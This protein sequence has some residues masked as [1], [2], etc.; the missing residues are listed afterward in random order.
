M[1]DRGVDDDTV[2]IHVHCS[3]RRKVRLLEYLESSGTAGQP[4]L[5]GV[6]V[7]AAQS[8]TYGLHYNV[9]GGSE[10]NDS[11]VWGGLV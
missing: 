9:D 4:N 11:Y 1:N 10:V 5:P 7:Q 3:R 8:A 2:L 6:R